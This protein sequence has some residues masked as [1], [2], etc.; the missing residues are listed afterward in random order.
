MKYYV[1]YLSKKDKIYFTIG[2]LA[3]AVIGAIT[4][5]ANS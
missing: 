1:T 4:L 3:T 5:F 2:I